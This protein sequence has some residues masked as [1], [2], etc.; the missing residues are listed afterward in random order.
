MISE[1][2]KS[3]L[4]SI[5]EG[6]LEKIIQILDDNPESIEQVTPFGT[7]LH[8]AASEGQLPIVKELIKRGLDVNA[9]G[10][11]SKGTALL[12]AARNNHYEVA[13]YLLDTGAKMDESASNRNP[14][15]GAILRDN[16]KIAQLL[17][18]RGIDI[19]IKYLFENKQTYDA[20]GFARMRDAT[21]CIKVLEKA[22][23][24]VTAK[25]KSKVAKSKK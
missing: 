2:K 11:I 16:A 21:E 13:R 18:D 8:Y 7:W 4:D 12:D 19:K 15:F 3:L 14:L 6:T 23:S 5:E 17:I 1:L 10:G 9:H 22:M 24:K 25:A 20:L